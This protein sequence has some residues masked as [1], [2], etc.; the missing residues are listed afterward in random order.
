VDEA[1][2]SSLKIVKIALLII[3]SMTGRLFP[4]YHPHSSEALVPQPQVGSASFHRAHTPD[5]S[6]L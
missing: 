2:Q 5:L 3:R 1:D 6:E 4:P